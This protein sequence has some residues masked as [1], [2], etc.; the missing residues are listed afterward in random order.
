MSTTKL[1]ISQC[2]TEKGFK[3]FTIK[4]SGS[5]IHV[6][7]WDIVTFEEVDKIRAELNEICGTLKDPKFNWLNVCEF[8]CGNVRFAK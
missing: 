2:L 5:F 1:S 6:S 3:D 7:L 4:K 8:H